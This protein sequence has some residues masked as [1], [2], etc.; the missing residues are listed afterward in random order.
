VTGATSKLIFVFVNINSLSFIFLNFIKIK[1]RGT[2]L[3]AVEVVYYQIT[4]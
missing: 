3:F 4:K 1:K 2:F